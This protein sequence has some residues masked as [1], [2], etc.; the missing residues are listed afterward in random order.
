MTHTLSIGY[1][2]GTIR[3]PMSTFAQDIFDDEVYTYWQNER[4]YPYDPEQIT[5]GKWDM[6]LSIYFKTEIEALYNKELLVIEVYKSQKSQVPFGS[7]SEKEYDGLIKE[8][9]KQRVKI[10]DEN[11]EYF[12]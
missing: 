2:M 6:M 3:N 12:I 5:I 8:R 7:P 10:M 9:E 11:L 4:T 1:N